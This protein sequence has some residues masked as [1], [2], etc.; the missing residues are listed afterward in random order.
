MSQYRII[1][2]TAKNGV[3]Y[4]FFEQKRW[5]GWQKVGYKLD[6]VFIEHVEYNLSAVHDYIEYMIKEEKRMLET[7]IIKKEVVW[8]GSK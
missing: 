6:D 5:W 1:K 8:I 3:E 4:F 7:K 2:K